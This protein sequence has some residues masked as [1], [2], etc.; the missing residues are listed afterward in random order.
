MICSSFNRWQHT[1]QLK[2][3]NQARHTIK[4]MLRRRKTNH[5]L[6]CLSMLLKRN[7]RATSAR[8]VVWKIMGSISASVHFHHFLS[9]ALCA[10]RR[11]GA[12]LLIVHSGLEHVSFSKY[13]V[14]LESCTKQSPL[15][16]YSCLRHSNPLT[17]VLNHLLRFFSPPPLK[18]SATKWLQLIVG[19]SFAVILAKTNLSPYLDVRRG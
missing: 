10:I 5:W 2:Q 16:V 4:G 18:L 19:S 14:Q 9:G 6:R 11:G 15:L 17:I 8:Y 1:F 3:P 13:D 12:S 7:L